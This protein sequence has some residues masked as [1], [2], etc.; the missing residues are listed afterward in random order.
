MPLSA[1]RDTTEHFS[2]T[3]QFPLHTELLCST[4]LSHQGQTL[5]KHFS[6]TALAQKFSPPSTSGHPTQIEFFSSLHRKLPPGE[7]ITEFLYK[8]IGSLDIWA[9][10]LG[11]PP[12]RGIN[13]LFLRFSNSYPPKEVCFMETKCKL[14]QMLFFT[15]GRKKRTSKY[16][17]PNRR[18]AFLWKK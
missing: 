14:N 16:A 10:L 4:S 5:P 15:S 9:V 17:N 7:D 3:T 11:F 18:L 1:T 6:K 8:K 2:F 12:S 13:S